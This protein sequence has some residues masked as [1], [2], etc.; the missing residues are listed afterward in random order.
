MSYIINKWALVRRRE[1]SVTPANIDIHPDFLHIL[2]RD[3]FET[4]FRYIGD[5]FFQIMTGISENPE[6]FAMPLFDEKT[7][8]YGAPE[9]QESR[10]AAWRPMKLLYAVF[11]QGCLKN[12]VFEVNI[13]EFKQVNKVKNIHILFNAFN[14]YGFVFSGLQNGKITPKTAGFSV[15]YP[16]NPNII[17][18]LALVA[19]KALNTGSETL[20]YKWSFRL[21]AEGFGKN[22]FSSPFYAVYD[23][24]RTD[25]ERKF[26][27]SFHE[28]MLDRDYFYAD[29]SW[30]EGPGINYYDKESVMK[31]KGPYLFRILDWMGELRLMLRIRNA[32]KCIEFYNGKDMPD[33]I[34]KMFRYS[35]SGCDIHA[36]GK[37]NKGVEYIFEEQVRWHC[38]C[39]NAPFWVHPKTESIHQYINLIESF[40]QKN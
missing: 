6:H 14:N 30:N 5:M 8:R 22:S 18:V 11:S 17:T 35:E 3:E 7:T 20:F 40:S 15:S 21:L 12:N 29:G 23:K 38:G 34:T 31:R 1:L 37:C 25:A 9:A 10:N 39:C 16:D 4:A 24:L 32:E 2:Q 36:A 27:K 33:E 13:P 19:E 26:I 28:T